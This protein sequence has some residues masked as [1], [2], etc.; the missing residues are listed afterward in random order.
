MLKAVSVQQVNRDIVVAV[1]RARCNLPQTVTLAHT[2]F[3]I[4]TLRD[5]LQMS[6]TVLLRRLASLKK[7]EHRLLCKEF[8]TLGYSILAKIFLVH[9]QR[10]V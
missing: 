1:L 6:K 4:K 9:M 8:F 10:T 7:L 5:L 3:K 2:G